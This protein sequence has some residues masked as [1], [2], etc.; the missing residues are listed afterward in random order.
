[1]LTFDRE[2]HL[3]WWNGTPVPS[4]TDIMQDVGLIV[5]KGRKAD[6][7]D[8]RIFGTAAH[9]GTELSDRRILNENTLDPKILPYLDCWKKAI[10]TYQF[11]IHDIEKSYY[12]RTLKFAGTIDRIVQYR[13]Y[14]YVLDIKTSHDIV[15]SAEIQTAAYKILYGDHCDAHGVADVGIRRMVVLLRPRKPAKVIIHKNMSEINVFKSALNV[16]K[17]RIKYGYTSIGSKGN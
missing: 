3:Y 15:P 1:M 17:R 9:L 8:A 7:E 2:K 14:I 13:G 4:V 12:H 5:L 10:Q 11:R 16:Y 6:I